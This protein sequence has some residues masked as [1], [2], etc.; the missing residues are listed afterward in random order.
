MLVLDVTG[1]AADNAGPIR[2][3]SNSGHTVTGS[4]HCLNQTVEM[5]GLERFAQPAD[6]Y[7]DST[8]FDKH[9]VSPHLVKQLGA[10]V[11]PFRVCEQKVE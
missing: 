7:V 5:F 6:V 8:L 10:R 4:A 11:D 2:I 9:V 3:A 1:S